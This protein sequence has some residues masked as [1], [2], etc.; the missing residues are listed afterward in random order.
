MNIVE[1]DKIPLQ[2]TAS[3]TY[4]LKKGM[5]VLDKP[6]GPTSHQAVSYLKDILDIEKAGHA[7]TLDPKVSGVLP[8][9]L[10]KATRIMKYLMK[11]GKEYIALMQ[12]H[13]DVSTDDL[14]PVLLNYEGVIEQVPPKKS[15]VKRQKRERTVHDIEILEKEG[16]DVLLRI[17][18]EAGTY[19][20]KLIHDMG[21]SLNVGA[22]MLE[23]R[24]TKSGIFD[25]DESFTLHDIKDNVAFY[26]EGIENN[27]KTILRPI[28]YALREFKR[29]QVY[30]SAMKSLSHGSY[31][32]KPGITNIDSSIKKG[33][34]VIVVNKAG[35]VILIGQAKLSAERIDRL[36]KG[37]VVETDQVY[38][39]PDEINHSQ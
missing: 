9:A 25:E 11:D 27:I 31:L 32:K 7:G 34:D 8:T 19:I 36:N 15:A 22:H 1:K 13:D 33:D 21:E 24:R 5:M 2:T 4:C 38:M 6:P 17:S 16:R 18:C 30:D 10:N 20:R 29:V 3:P 39:E 26:D 28:E 12:L 23:L 37:I 14:E 35:K